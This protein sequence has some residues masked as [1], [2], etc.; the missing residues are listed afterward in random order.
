MPQLCPNCS[1]DNPD[2]APTCA[3]CGEPLR[4]LLG[5]NALLEGRY[6][7][8]HVLGCGGMGAVYLADDTRMPGR[9]VAVKENLNT[10][11]QAQAQ[12][13]HEVSLMVKLD[14]RG[15]PKVSDQFI[16]PSG[17]QYLVMDYVEGETLEDVV[18]RRGPLPE[19]EVITL[20]GQLLEVLEYLHNHSVVHRDV[21]PANIKL[22]PDGKPVLVDF[23]I[24]KL[25][26]PG[27]RTRTW[28]QGVGSPGFA[29]LEQY[30]T[31]TDARSDLYSLGAVMYYLLTG[32]SP[33]EAPDLAAGTP[34]TPPRRLRPDLSPQVHGVV[35]KAMGL[36]PV[37][38]YQSAAEMRQALDAQSVQRE[39]VGRTGLMA[40]AGVALVALALIGAAILAI[41]RINQGGPPA[42]PR[43]A[44]IPENPPS[45]PVASQV[46]SADASPAGF[47]PAA[48]D[49]GAEAAADATRTAQAA[50]A[51]T[52]ATRQADADSA[53]ATATSVATVPAGR[54]AFY[55]TRDGNEEI[56][57]MNADGSQQTRLTDHPA[58]DEVPA[59]SPN[60]QR[61]AFASERDSN[62]EIYV[63][64]ADGSDQTRLT[65][66]PAEDRL[67]IWS[68]D[69]G[70]IAFNSDRAGS[71]DLYAMNADGSG[72]VRLTSG[73]ERDGHTTW[74]PDGRQIA[75]NSGPSE[76]Q[77]EIYIMAAAGGDWLRLTENSFI[78]WS[79]SWSPG[80]EYILFL[81]KR[82]DN[83][84]I[85]LMQTDGSHQEKL[86]GTPGYEWGA[87]W[88]PD[89]QYIAF[90]S[91]QDGENNIYIMH[92]DGSDVRQVTHEG[93]AYP[94]WSELTP[95]E[96]AT[97]ALTPLLTGGLIAY[98]GGPEG[99]WQI[100]F[101]DPTSGETWLLPGQLP[102][103]GVPAWSPDGSHLAFR[104]NDGGAWQIYTMRA[105]G[106]DLR[107]LTFG[108]DDN[109]EA[110]W[111][112][113]G[114]HIAYVSTRDGNKE[115]YVMDP[116]GKNARRLTANPEWDDDPS[117]SSDG[118][119]LAFESKREGRMDIYKMHADG[120]S[121]V[122]LTSD[123]DLNSTPA[124]SPDG[125]LIA[126]ERKSGSVYHIWIM[127]ADGSA[128]WQLTSD[129][130]R[131]LRP[132][133]SPDGSEI[134]YT[135]DRGGGQ[136]VW[137]CPLDKG[138][139][140]RRLSP[141][142]GFDAAWSR[143]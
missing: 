138:E 54:I 139:A 122:R 101:A 20:A 92:A 125:K 123:G 72:L 53:T 103:S 56:Y 42:E 141:G 80:G 22:R 118:K 82:P 120:S 18:E 49:Q 143:R 50:L 40:M 47:T 126:F 58:N 21:K 1:H 97:Q 63:M 117:W 107:Q 128:Q 27:Q 96:S 7:V 3:G 5:Q 84:D 32:Q 87:I 34:L 86:F 43:T 66:D 121:L 116:D 9:R 35:F 61:V 33:P 85:Y 70:R 14:H 28:A 132:A 59:L 8:T 81:S 134:A 106:T 93:G 94:S 74:S 62:W 137:I 133:W 29:P 25:H 45:Q 95:T 36:N 124:W 112:P 31:G 46:S 26:A 2:N 100:F 65:Y 30:G 10:T 109:L 129:G 13:Q 119:W 78:D 67:P 41:G 11:P 102:N 91:D 6:Q 99:A 24:A 12:F 15:L 142:Q 51:L 89:G 38:R 88:S 68:P 71:L 140:P 130:K 57:I 76:D 77:W 115:I 110:A 37:Q 127:N 135:S 55:S 64:N 113:H 108:M 39:H 60:G 23:G 90:T 83:A 75:F 104:S 111:S 73:P 131:N 4:G 44:Q 48:E 105:D 16:G 19:A 79:P 136:A 98:A 114:T 17:R 69:G 52:A